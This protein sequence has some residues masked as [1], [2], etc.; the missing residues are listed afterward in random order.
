MLWNSWP[1]SSAPSARSAIAV[2]WMGLYPESFMRPMRNDVGRLLARLERVAPAGDS[3]LTL[4]EG[5]MHM[6]HGA[7]H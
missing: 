4:G 6:D 7:M 3:A 5:A 1:E 2:F